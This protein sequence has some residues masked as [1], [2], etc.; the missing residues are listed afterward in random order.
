MNNRVALADKWLGDLGWE[1]EHSRH[2]RDLA[3]MLFDQ[4]RPQH[5]LGEGY[6]DILE[7]AALLHDIG[8]TISGAKHHKLSY[9]MIRD[10]SEHLEGFDK[11][12]VKLIALT[13]RYHRKSHPQLKH[14]PYAKLSISDQMIV[15][16]LAAILRIADGLDRPHH[17][18][19]KRVNCR[20]QD[21]RV[22]VLVKAETGLSDCL[23]GAERKKALFEE[24]FG[25]PVDLSSL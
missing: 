6:R 11:R 3:L 20:M 7:A 21:G 16:K 24:V 5:G 2:V 4:L 23:A 13:A 17:Q 1:A 14:G 19:V 10:N 12:E 8:W 15:N 22:Q 9:R 18:T 25:L